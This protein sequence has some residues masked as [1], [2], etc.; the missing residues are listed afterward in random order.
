MLQ[1]IL[2]KNRSRSRGPEYDPIAAV[3]DRILLGPGFHLNPTFVRRHNVTHIVNCAEKSACPAWASTHVGPSAYIALG[4]D[5]TIGFPLIKDY[6]PT[7]EKVMDMFL[8]EPTCKCVYVHCMAG[9]NRSA[10]LLAAYLHK[11]FGIPMEKVVEVM[12]KQRPCV[13]TNPSFVEQLEEFARK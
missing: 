2:D 5:D 1:P 12:A 6:Y 3:F 13:M 8:R 10:T 4:A 7:F 9:M 11:R